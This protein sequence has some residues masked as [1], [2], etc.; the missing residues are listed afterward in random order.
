MKILVVDDE[1]D[2]CDCLVMLLELKGHF[3]IKA[4]SGLEGLE[5]VGKYDFDLIISD[6]RMPDCDGIQ[7][8]EKLKEKMN[9]IPPFI[10]MSGFSELTKEDVIANGAKGLVKKP[11]LFADM[12]KIIEE[13]KK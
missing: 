13:Y 6:I 3:A 1:P 5:A 11:I 8:L 9:P 4:I 2:I 10:Y 7:F 12:I